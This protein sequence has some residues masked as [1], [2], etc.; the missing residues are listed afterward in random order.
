[1]TIQEDE[2]AEVKLIPIDILKFE[3]KNNNK[4]YVPHGADYYT[5]IF[6]AIE[7]LK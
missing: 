1:L 5:R 2:V 7:Q 3:L 6:D 4:N